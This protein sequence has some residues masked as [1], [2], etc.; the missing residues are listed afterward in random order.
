LDGDENCGI[1]NMS[2]QPV[3]GL[4]IFLVAN[5]EQVFHRRLHR[6]LYTKTVLLIYTASFTL[7]SV[8]CV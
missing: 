5:P 6:S 2:A 4:S 1:A 8:C 3:E 7:A